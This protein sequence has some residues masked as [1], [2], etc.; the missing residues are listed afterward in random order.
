[1]ETAGRQTV[2]YFSNFILFLVLN[3]L[4]IIV[5]IMSLGGQLLVCILG[6]L[7][8]C[9]PAAT[10]DAPGNP[11]QSIVDRNVFGLR[12]P[13]PT[14]TNNPEANKPPPAKITLT[15]IITGFTG[16]KRALMKRQVPPKPG[17]PPNEQSL[18]MTVGQREGE[19]EVLEINEVEG[20]VKVSESGS[21]TV[22][23]LE[24]PPSSPAPGPVA[25]AGAVPNPGFAPA[26]TSVAAPNP[27]NT[28]GLKTIP[29]RTLRTA[30]ATGLGGAGAPIGAPQ[31]AG[32]ALNFGTPNAQQQASPS[33]SLP[34]MTEA[35]SYI[36]LE[37]ERERLKAKGDP[38]AK[39]L[40]PTPF[41]PK[42]NTAEDPEG[43]APVVPPSV[44][45]V[46][47]R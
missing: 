28:G 32:A 2:V 33:D 1:V 43:N 5:I 3:L 7:A 36:L 6:G 20:T 24:K 46:R 12:T 27:F 15:G 45:P 30:A 21:V 42:V 22:L 29:T 16:S 23:N 8:L 47:R 9:A 26:G 44:P 11:Y 13:P 18:I 34:P 4:P 10:A 40:P 31:Q 19:V 35:E 39:L 38:M 14:P 25:A 17:S 41:N 37:A